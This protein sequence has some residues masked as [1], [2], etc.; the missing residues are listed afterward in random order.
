MQTLTPLDRAAK[1]LYLL[2][3]KVYFAILQFCIADYQALLVMYDL[4][5]YAKLV[6][7][8]DDLMQDKQ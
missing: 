7:F 2:G 4:N 8:L 5:I 1:H 6:E 3:R